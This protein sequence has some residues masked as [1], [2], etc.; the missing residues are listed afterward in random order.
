MLEVVDGVGYKYGDVY[1]FFVYVVNRSLEEGS[2]TEREM[3]NEDGG[4]MESR[5]GEDLSPNRRP[6]SRQGGWVPY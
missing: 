1:F 4:Y 6:P 2:A 3:G 5:A